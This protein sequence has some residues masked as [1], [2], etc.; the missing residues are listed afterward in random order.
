MP[1]QRRFASKSI[2]IA[3]CKLPAD[4]DE[5]LHVFIGQMLEAAAVV[6]E[7]ADVTAGLAL[8]RGQFEAYPVYFDHPGWQP[9][10]AE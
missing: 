4:A 5:T 7:T 6:S 2:L 9:I 10:R 1:S 3:N 8:M